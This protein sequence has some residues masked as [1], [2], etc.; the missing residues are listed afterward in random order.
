MQD[1]INLI[2]QITDRSFASKKIK[3]NH[4]I[5]NQDF[6]NLEELV[7]PPQNPKIDDSNVVSQRQSS[8][9]NDINKLD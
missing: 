1:E 8:S 6:N 4:S 9:S 7:S 3:V 2:G 5:D